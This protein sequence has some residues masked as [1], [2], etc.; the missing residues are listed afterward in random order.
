MKIVAKAQRYLGLWINMKKMRSIT[1]I[2]NKRV[3]FVA[4][5]PSKLSVVRVLV[6]SLAVSDTF[7]LSGDHF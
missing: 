5:I 7:Y 1:I 3:K 4:L 2:A 6:G